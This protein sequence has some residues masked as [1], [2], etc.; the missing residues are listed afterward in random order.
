[1]HICKNDKLHISGERAGDG[2]GRESDRGGSDGQ[3][4]RAAMVSSVGGAG[5]V[6][7]LSARDRRHQVRSPRHFVSVPRDVAERQTAAATDDV[8][9]RG[10]RQRPAADRP[11]E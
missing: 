2:F 11:E 10:R 3:S 7:S 5:R 6:S 8:G 4:G 1:M 9:R